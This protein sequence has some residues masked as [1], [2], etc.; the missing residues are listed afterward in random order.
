MKR[1]LFTLLTLFLFNSNIN[2]EQKRVLA[3]EEAIIAIPSMNS[4]NFHEI[5]TAIAA[6]DGVTLRGYCEGSRCFLLT[7]DTKKVESAE[8]IARVIENL[9]S[10]YKPEIKVGTSINQ[11]I[12]SCTTYNNTATGSTPTVE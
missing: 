7:Y 4:K 11:I 9:N 3:S 12:N 8:V 5:K 2:S 1:I 6:I 10:R